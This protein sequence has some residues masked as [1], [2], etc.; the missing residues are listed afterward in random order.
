MGGIHK[1]H[2]QTPFNYLG[3]CYFLFLAFET[4]VV[5][6]FSYCHF[7][8]CFPLLHYDNFNQNIDLKITF[9]F[10]P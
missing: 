7:I 3:L 10:Q 2:N 4:C 5:F 8:L 6:Y 9:L 1:D